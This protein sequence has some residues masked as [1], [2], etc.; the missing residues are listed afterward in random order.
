MKKSLK[1]NVPV[2]IQ[3]KHKPDISLEGSLL[4]QPLHEE[5]LIT[6]NQTQ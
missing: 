6:H 5:L 2:G 1:R 4:C 3:I